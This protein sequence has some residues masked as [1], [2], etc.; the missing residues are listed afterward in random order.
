MAVLHAGMSAAEQADTASNILRRGNIS[1]LLCIISRCST[2]GGLHSVS[3]TLPAVA[4]ICDLINP[5]ACYVLIVIV[6]DAVN[7]QIAHRRRDRKRT[8]QHTFLR[9]IRLH[10]FARHIAG[11]FRKIMENKMTKHTMITALQQICSEGRE[12]MDANP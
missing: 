1:G 3:K 4:C 10:H 7:W 2:I 5:R 11:S 6:T 12:Q 8:Q 9:G